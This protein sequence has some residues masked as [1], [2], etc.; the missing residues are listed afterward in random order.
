MKQEQIKV[1]ITQ[2]AIEKKEL[3]LLSIIIAAR[4]QKSRQDK[5]YNIHSTLGVKKK[6]RTGADRPEMNPLIP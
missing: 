6:T 4:T 2:E 1:K 5:I 3:Y